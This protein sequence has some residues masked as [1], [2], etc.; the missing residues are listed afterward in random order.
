[1]ARGSS[2]LQNGDNN[3][4]ILKRSLNPGIGLYAGAVGTIINIGFYNIPREDKIE[5]L[6][7]GQSQSVFIYPIEASSASS[8]YIMIGGKIYPIIYGTFNVSS[9]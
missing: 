9:I 5:I 7:E 6:L 8:G 4:I 2:T 3:V 1:M